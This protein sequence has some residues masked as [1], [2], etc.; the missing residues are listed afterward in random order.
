MIGRAGTAI[1]QSNFPNP[2]ITKES[3]TGCRSV[4]NY[5]PFKCLENHYLIPESPGARIPGENLLGRAVV[6][7]TNEQKRFLLIT[8]SIRVRDS[9]FIR[10]MN[11]KATIETISPLH[12][13]MGMVPK[14][15]MLMFVDAELVCKVSAGWNSALR[16]ANGAIHVVESVHVESVPVD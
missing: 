3:G 1:E 6:P 14:G 11:H 9:V 15:P 16:E 8:I 12:L 4:S 5:Y 7:V 10:A 2:L 13:R